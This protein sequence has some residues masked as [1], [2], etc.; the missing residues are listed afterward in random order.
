[1]KL[2]EL[3]K[4]ILDENKCEEYLREVGILKS[5]TNCPKCESD[6]LGMIRG[7]RYRCYT[8]K[9][10]WTRRKGSVL[11]VTRFSNAEFLICLKYFSLE[12]SAEQTS[13]EFNLNY[14]T[15]RT[16]FQLFRMKMGDLTEKDIERFSTI[17]KNE[18]E[19]IGLKYSDG[20]VKFELTPS[21]DDDAKIKAIRHRVQNS[22]AYY[23][24]T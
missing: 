18:T 24:F 1:M 2:L 21:S 8:C 6:K 3:N 15:V 13:Q 5:F 20:K 22:A 16:L 23:E 7:D 14:K 12:F 10:E 19:I 9:N 11:S 4:I 17:I